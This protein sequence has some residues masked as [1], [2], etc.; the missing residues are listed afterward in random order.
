MARV[1]M[2]SVAS[3]ENVVYSVTKEVGPGC[4]NHRDDVLLVQYFL[5]EVP[6]YVNCPSELKGMKVEVNGITSKTFFEQILAFQKAALKASGVLMIVDGK[7]SPIPR[8]PKVAHTLQMLGGLYKANR[9]TDFFNITLA[10]DCP[11]ELTKALQ[12]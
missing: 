1:K 10:S 11:S 9:P 3:D 6:K 5:R 2:I 8:F 12:S 7:V 4:P